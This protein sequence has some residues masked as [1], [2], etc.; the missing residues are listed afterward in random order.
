[1]TEFERVKLRSAV[2]QAWE[3]SE[4]RQ[5][6]PIPGPIWAAVA[7]NAVIEELKVWEERKERALTGKDTS[8]YTSNTQGE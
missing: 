7:V 4:L 6:Q 1:M 8:G 2:M 3:V 5:F